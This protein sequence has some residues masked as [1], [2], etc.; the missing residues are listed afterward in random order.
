[1]QGMGILFQVKNPFWTLTPPP[2]VVMNPLGYYCAPNQAT[3]DYVASY[4]IRDFLAYGFICCYDCVTPE[5][6]TMWNMVQAD[7]VKWLRENFLRVVEKLILNIYAGAIE[8]PT[9]EDDFDS[10]QWAESVTIG[11][12]EEDDANGEQF[13]FEWAPGPV[14]ED[15]LAI[16]LRS[17]LVSGEG[18]G[19]DDEVI[20]LAHEAIQDR[21]AVK[22]AIVEARTINALDGSDVY[23]GWE[24]ALA[25]QA[26]EPA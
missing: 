8:I 6:F 11:E 26:A 22:A 21:A 1:M 20:W 10:G 4:T 3:P 15:A 16:V 25:A 12:S 24:E 19:G 23:P 2:G 17:T 14:H 9:K 18:T 7:D 13:V 5:N